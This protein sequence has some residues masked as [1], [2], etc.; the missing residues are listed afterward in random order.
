M[1]P[2]DILI[3]PVSLLVIGLFLLLHLWESVFPRKKNLPKIK[4]STLRGVLSFLVFFYLG[5]YLP[6]LTDEFLASF[7]LMDLS[8]LNTA[9]QVVI[10]LFFYQ[11]MLYFYHISVHKSNLLWRVFHQMHHSS[12]RLD[13]PSTYYFSLMDMVGFTLLASF[14]FAFFMGLAPMAISIIIFS[15][16]FLSQFQHANIRTPQWLGWFIQRPEQHAIHHARGQHKYNYSDFPIYD[17]LF[18]TFA[19]PKDFQDQ[20]GFYDGASARVKDML[21]FKDVSIKTK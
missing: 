17:Y 3:N 16:N 18:G 12:E 13:I 11:F 9:L 2:I 7:Q 21:L 6:L 8:S 19:N 4:F 14:C 15:L 5:S 1:N 20:N 10:G